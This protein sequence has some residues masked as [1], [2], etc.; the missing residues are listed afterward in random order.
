MTTP[1]QKSGSCTRNMRKSLLERTKIRSG[2]SELDVEMVKKFHAD[3]NRK[4]KL[5][6]T[7]KE[8]DL[9]KL[10]S[11]RG[12]FAKILRALIQSTQF[13]DAAN[14]IDFFTRQRLPSNEDLSPEERELL[15]MTFKPQFR[16]AKN[17]IAA[18]KAALKTEVDKGCDVLE[19]H[20]KYDRIIQ[21]YKLHIRF[22]ME[23]VLNLSEK[24]IAEQLI[25]RV[26]GNLK[27][28]FAGMCYFRILGD[29]T[30]YFSECFDDAGIKG[31][32]EH[33][34][35]SALNASYKIGKEKILDPMLLG[36][37]INCAQ[38]IDKVLN[39]PHE[40]LGLLNKYY[41]LLMKEAMRFSLDIEAESL[42]LLNLM[43]EVI[44]VIED[45]LALLQ[46]EDEK[47]S[48]VDISSADFPEPILQVSK[49]ESC[50]KGFKAKSNGSDCREELN[51][52]LE[53]L[54]LKKG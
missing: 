46:L 34:Y 27:D 7:K 11:D 52:A 48:N 4:R 12:E 32:A 37:L 39:R 10:N 31:K 14:Y 5:H 22:E 3:K 2:F 45:K 41:P 30:R 23:N 21:I 38:F 44:G 26:L 51:R 54:R 50:E 35:F 8:V 40:A 1:Q 47:S 33:Y 16:K 20:V 28:H 19:T 36:L 42:R 29:F 49:S 17:M 13:E 18:F 53:D 24:I 43:N 25:P 6:W 9:M 15:V